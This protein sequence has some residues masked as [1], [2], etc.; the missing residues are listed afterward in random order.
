MATM[1]KSFGAMERLI[2]LLAAAQ[3]VRSPEWYAWKKLY[4][5]IAAFSRVTFPTDMAMFRVKVGF[6]VEAHCVVNLTTA[7]KYGLIAHRGSFRLTTL[8]DN[9]LFGEV[10]LG[11]DAIALEFGP[12][13]ELTVQERK[14][15]RDYAMSFEGK[16]SWPALLSMR[17]FEEPWSLCLDEVRWF[18]EVLH[19][20]IAAGRLVR[21]AEV[22]AVDSEQEVVVERVFGE[23]ECY[24]VNTDF[25][26][27]P[28]EAPRYD[29]EWL[30]LM[31]DALPRRDGTLD[32]LYDVT[33]L[34]RLRPGERGRYE[35]TA[36]WV[37]NGECQA[38]HIARF[39]VSDRCQGLVDGLLSII[40]EDDAIPATVRVMTDELHAYYAPLASI[41]G[42]ELVKVGELS[43]VEM[44]YE[45]LWCG[46]E[47]LSIF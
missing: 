4:E 6:G 1:A 30:E 5:A 23:W 16:L 26:L 32:V 44:V 9:P 27:A 18:T 39:F 10:L 19:G 22:F 42:F 8:E 3:E 31:R 25:Q 29:V 43:T 15:I 20:V 45:H 47:Q 38:R 7:G 28:F 35:G 37:V 33:G 2:D 17:P 13:E 34:Y 41:L 46:G 14:R 12:R 40:L 11:L 36:L 21:N 24:Q